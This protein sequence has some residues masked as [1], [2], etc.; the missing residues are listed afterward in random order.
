MVYPLVIGAL[1]RDM[2]L[3]VVMIVNPG[4]ACSLLSVRSA[5]RPLCITGR[6]AAL[7]HA[8]NAQQRMV[9]NAD[10][11]VR[12]LNS[13]RGRALLSGMCPALIAGSSHA[14]PS[15]LCFRSLNISGAEYGEFDGLRGV[16]FTL[17]LG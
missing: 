8:S 2:L 3:V 16:H 15:D 6:S 14:G 5:Y 4:W 13:R 10:M 12:A 7:R 9:L 11:K 17:P 1:R